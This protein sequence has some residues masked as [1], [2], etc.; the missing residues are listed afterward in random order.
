MNF[1]NRLK[2]YLIGVGLGILL[3]L[4][5]FKDRKLTSWTPENQVKRD[6]EE[7]EL[8]YNEDIECILT[9]HDLANSDLVRDYL[10][11]GEVDFSESN[12]KDHENR[13]YQLVFD[14]GEIAELQVVIGE[15]KVQITKINA[16]NRT[17]P[18]N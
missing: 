10:L 8:S 15:D 5:I 9:C 17:C 18:C 13:V 14:G 7:K 3:V 4:A 12:V 2:F 16:F 11:H 6:I 1:L